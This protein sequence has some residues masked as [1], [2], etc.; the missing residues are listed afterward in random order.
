VLT[1]LAAVENEPMRTTP[2]PSEHSRHLGDFISVRD[3]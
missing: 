3:G 2:G 1:P